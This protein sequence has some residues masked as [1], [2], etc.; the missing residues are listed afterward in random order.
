MAATWK[1]EFP[2][3]RSVGPVIGAFLA[4]LRDR[5]VVGVR[6]AGGRVLVPPFEYDPETGEA[7]GEMVDVASDRGRDV[8]RRGWPSRCARIRSTVRSRGR[9]CARRR[10][11]VVCCT[12]STAGSAGS[13]RARHARAHPLGRR[14]RRPPLRHRVLRGRDMTVTD[15]PRPGRCSSCRTT[16]RWSTRSP[17]RLRA[18]AALRRSAR[19]RPHHRPQVPA[20]RQVYMPPRGYC[21]LCVGRDDRGQRGRGRRPRHGHDVLGDHAAAVPGPGGEPRTTCRPRSCSTAPTPRS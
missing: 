15:N 17:S 3:R 1:L 13:R 4:G 2:Y 10:R 21:P 8:V 7:A 16:P 12:R 18:R 20:V 6:T 5:Q 14:D 19:R 11:H 9:S